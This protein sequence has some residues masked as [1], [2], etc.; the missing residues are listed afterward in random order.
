MGDWFSG[1][2]DGV[3]D[4]GSWLLETTYNAFGLDNAF[5][6]LFQNTEGFDVWDFVSG[7]VESAPEETYIGMSETIYPSGQTTYGTE[8]IASSA[9]VG[10]LWDSISNWASS[11]EGMSTIF[12]GLAGAGAGGLNYLLANKKQKAEEELLKEKLKSEKEI[13]QMKEKGAS[14]R[15]GEEEQAAERLYQ[16]KLIKPIGRVDTRPIISD[17]NLLR[18]NY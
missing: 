8:N 3:L 13:A 17:V 9:N 2:V 6:D 14:R 4:T 7:G 18:R 12:T 1:L 5:G 11:P 15:I 16:S 10:S